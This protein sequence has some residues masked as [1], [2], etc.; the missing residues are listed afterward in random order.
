MLLI[1]I[2]LRNQF[3][4]S[5]IFFDLNSLYKM[6]YFKMKLDLFIDVC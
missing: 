5:D 6:I 2:W 1:K 4:F 3:R